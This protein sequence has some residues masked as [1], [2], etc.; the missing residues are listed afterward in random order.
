HL[1]FFPA[2]IATATSQFI[3]AITTGVGAAS[4]LALGHVLLGPALSMGVG[5]VVGA[6]LGAAL[7]RRLRGT[8]IVRLLSLALILAGARLI[9]AGLS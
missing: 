3:L 2:H 9:W 1:F 6:P 8:L 4:H 7:S 5:V